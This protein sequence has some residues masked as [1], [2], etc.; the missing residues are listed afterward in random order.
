LRP[1]SKNKGIVRLTH[2]S[3]GR[4]EHGRTSCHVC[5]RVVGNEDSRQYG[6]SKLWVLGRELHCNGDLGLGRE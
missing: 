2:S 3:G 6:T 4:P 1:S 5:Q